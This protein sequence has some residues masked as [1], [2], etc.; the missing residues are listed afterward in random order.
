[1]LLNV[2]SCYCTKYHILLI[3]RALSRSLIYSAVKK[4]DVADF[5]FRVRLIDCLTI[6]RVAVIATFSVVFHNNHNYLSTNLITKILFLILKKLFNSIFIINFILSAVQ[7]YSFIWSILG[8][9]NRL[10]QFSLSILYDWPY[11][12]KYWCT[13]KY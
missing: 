2:N 7:N 5:S 10:E 6:I 4:F 11:M 13:L 1:M 3:I 12:P 8:S 9:V